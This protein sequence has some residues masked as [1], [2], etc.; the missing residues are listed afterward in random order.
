MTNNLRKK[1]E[2]S[3]KLKKRIRKKRRR[4][5]VRGKTE[6]MQGRR[7]NVMV[8]AARHGNSGK[9]ENRRVRMGT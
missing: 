3:H 1:E 9:D 4:K 6:G 7:Q 5:S 2:E 8:V